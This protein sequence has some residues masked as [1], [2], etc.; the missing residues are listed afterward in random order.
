MNRLNFDFFNENVKK[1]LILKILY[2]GFFETHDENY[3]YYVFYKFI[4]FYVL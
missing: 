3:I 4:I 1:P 2:V